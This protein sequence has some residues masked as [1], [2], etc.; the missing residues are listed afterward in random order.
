MQEFH[1]YLSVEHNASPHTLDA[2]RRDL[3][4][5]FEFLAH[6]SVESH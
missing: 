2:Y 3:T 6:H 1:R 4:Q 5:F